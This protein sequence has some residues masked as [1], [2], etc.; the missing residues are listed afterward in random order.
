MQGLDWQPL[1]FPFSRGLNQ[2][3][4]PRL[5]RAPELVR[6]VNVE[7]GDLG[8]LRLR[9]PYA[10]IGSS[11]FGGGTISNCRRIYACGDELVLFT[12][13]A[14]FSWSAQ[15]SAWVRKG[16]HLAAKV[17]EQPTFINTS[18]QDD[19]DRAQLSGTVVYCWRQT[20]TGV[21][22]VF[23]A[24]ADATTGAVL[25][26]PTDVAPGTR[27]RVV[28]LA[29]T[30]VL[31]YESGT[32]SLVARTINPSTLAVSGTT[33]ILAAASFNSYYDVE[34]IPA[35][36]TAIV[37]CRRDVTTSYEI[38]KVT[39]ALAV[40]A[41]TKA[42][43]C[44][45]P[46][47]VAC[48]ADG[49]SVQIAR[50]NG[51][52]V[53]GDL[54]TISSL[55]DVNTGQ[56]LGAG[57]STLYQI[58][59]AFVDSTT[60]HVFW[61]S[62]QSVAAV[63]F[64]T[65]HN[66]VTVASAVGTAASFKRRVGVASRAFA[67]GG[68]AFVWLAFA[69]ESSFSGANPSEFRAQLQNTYF[70][71][72]SDGL[73]C[74]KAAWQRGAGFRTIASLPNVALT[75]GSTTFSFCGGERRII[76]LGE[77]QSGYADTGPRDIAITFDSNE[78]R[79]VARLGAT[80]YIAGGGEVLQYDGRELVEVGFHLYP[81]Y[82]GSIE[83]GTGNLADGVYTLKTS[84]RYD[85]ARAERERS[86]SATHGQVTI[87]AGP[88][89]IST[90]SWIPLYVTHKSG[91]AAESWRTKV[92]SAQP[93]FKTTSSDPTATSNPNRYVEND[94]TAGTLSTLNDELA[95]ADLAKLEPHPENDDVLENLAPPAATLIA[96]SADRIFLAGIPAE[97]NL[98]VYSKLRGAGEVAAFHD[99][100]VVRVPEF[101]G[102]I[103]ALAFAGETPIVFCETA[104]FALAGRGLPNAGGGANYEAQEVPGDVG[105]ISQE[106]IA[107]TPAGLIFKSLKG[108]YLLPRGL[109]A[110]EY[111]GA[112]V[113][114]YDSET[115]HAAHVIET[116]HQ[117]RIV[118]SAR[119][120]IF[121]YTE[122]SPLKWAEWDI[123]DGLHACMWNGVYHYLA[124]GSVKA[125]QASHATTT[126]GLDV[127]MLVHLGALQ[128]FSRVR[129]IL[130][131]G[132][133][134]GESNLRWRVGGYEE[135]SYFD[136]ESTVLDEDDYDVGD[137]L[138]EQLGPSEQ[139]Q[140]ALRVRL[141]SSL[142]VES[143]GEQV[144]LTALTL[145]VGFK[146]SV[147]PRIPAHARH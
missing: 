29:T 107:R 55:A 88:N 123:G 25:L 128:G 60:C 93:F 14:F 10:N 13:T 135:D 1:E 43:T 34:K 58:T 104:I 57:T 63:D 75:S 28:A 11:I 109:G 18:N 140:K 132:E 83:V 105:A 102:A 65:D 106:S 134:R 30:I 111:I 116:K 69:G 48:T 37:A 85:N 2:K 31:F 35:A 90:V 110:P 80:L 8:G 4:D 26:T 7:F 92:N 98:L 76:Q 16:T 136:D 125:E 40:T 103:T 62:N 126:H 127:E 139:Q 137:E 130:V 91:I 77:K 68:S 36:D 24:A 41:S 84:W 74:A 47:A 115:V 96:A 42:R 50:G 82:F 145:E 86:A 51:S 118:T 120:L 71:Y 124:T 20:V 44:D 72:R 138:E 121:D 15:R 19:C 38:L 27:P 9:Y 94:P 101:G 21:D 112:D 119:V 32:G 113:R 33:T 67:Y 146:R 95:D 6:A 66:T 53:Q 129:R 100:L 78:A 133:F 3:S 64:D 117:V 70:L 114:D 87:A 79:R 108:W 144:R 5:V 81:H 22:E 23:V 54:V 45:G 17:T 141:T 39:S 56:A 73:L 52:N 147:T 89:G 61:H 131:L 59:A 99:T 12:D 122:G 142:P 143:F 97:P 49:T 46:I